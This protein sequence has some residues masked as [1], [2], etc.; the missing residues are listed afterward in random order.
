MHHTTAPDVT[1]IKTSALT[2]LG[3]AVYFLLMKLIGLNEIV[4]LR[5]LNFFILMYGIRYILIRRRAENNGELEYL[6]GMMA[7]FMTGLF[8]A[9]LF[10]GFLYIYLHVDLGFLNYLKTTQ[11]LGIHLTPLSAVLV[12]FLEEVSISAIISFALVHILN[13]DKD[14]G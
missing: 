10:S 11:S 5:Y 12:T 2:A 14:N 4:E 9:V 1:L 8:A 3:M 6:H 7:G 13:R